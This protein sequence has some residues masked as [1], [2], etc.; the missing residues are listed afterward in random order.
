MRSL[1]DV[2]RKAYSAGVRVWDEVACAFDEDVRPVALLVHDAADVAIVVNPGSRGLPSEAL[3]P[4]E[5]RVL[6]EGQRLR[7]AASARITYLNHNC[8]SH[9]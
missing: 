2:K 4:T 6:S 9:L 5:S 8:A 7:T 1:D 3:D